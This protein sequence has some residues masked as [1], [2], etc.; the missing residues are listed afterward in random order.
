VKIR[1]KLRSIRKDLVRWNKKNVRLSVK[2]I[3]HLLSHPE[4]TEDFDAVTLRRL[5]AYVLLRWLDD[6]TSDL[7]GEYFPF[8]LPS[9][10]FYRR[11]CQLH[12]LLEEL[13][14]L[15]NFPH[16][17]LSTLQTISRHLKS[18][19][20]DEGVVAAAERLEKAEALFGEVRKVLRLSSL[21]N[22]RLLRGR[23]PS[24]KGREA[25]EKIEKGLDQWRDRLSQRILR[26]R[27]NDKRDDAQT[28]LQY[29]E[30]YQQQLVGHVLLLKG[31]KE[32]FVVQRTNNLLEHR[33]GATKQ[34]IRRKV[35]T[36]KLAR[37]VQA[38]R[39]E[40]MLV[41]NL[42]DEQYLE[43]VCDG[44]LDNLPDS[45]AKHWNS[46]RVVRSERQKHQTEH[47][48]PTS[49]KQLRQPKLLESI[50]LTVTKMV[51]RITQKK[52]AA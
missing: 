13:T 50:K 5:V 28:V 19:R 32:P 40:A 24:Q 35:G 37:Y 8:D 42:K 6:Y 44:S 14:A 23:G 39:A 41:G 16:R 12:Q 20:E 29:F 10:A 51:E 34:A 27:D 46:A 4:E 48:M 21:P 38:M 52:L 26:E 33:F 25:V 9:L 49:K 45:F 3:D 7:N 47:P 1:A 43:L 30:K 22:Q 17:E 36:K 31:R 15:P 2:Q 11:G 18:L